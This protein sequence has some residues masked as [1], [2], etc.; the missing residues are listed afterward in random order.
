MHLPRTQRPTSG[1]TIHL[2]KDR[3]WASRDSKLRGSGD[4]HAR[5]AIGVTVEPV[6]EIGDAAKWLS[7]GSL[8]VRVGKARID[9]FNGQQ[10]T[11]D[12]ATAERLARV[13]LA[14]L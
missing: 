2:D 13:V 3:P 7:S 6:R 4:D 11:L 5:M 14:N 12:E 10:G 9:I 8:S 1:G